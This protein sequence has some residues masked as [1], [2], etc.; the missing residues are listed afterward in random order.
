[1]SWLDKLKSGDP[2]IVSSGLGGDSVARVD[3][4]T[5]T[6]IITAKRAARIH[7]LSSCQ[8]R[9]MPD[10]VLDECVKLVRGAMRREG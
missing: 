7:Y 3:R 9:T 8:W 5:K 1:M 10:D 2:V 6:Q 4:I